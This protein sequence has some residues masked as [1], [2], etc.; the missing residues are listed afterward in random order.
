M[1]FGDIII[2]SSDEVRQAAEAVAVLRQTACEKAPPSFHRLNPSATL[3]IFP[4]TIHS[5]KCYRPTYVP[6][7]SHH[8]RLKDISLF[9]LTYET[10]FVSG[11]R[12]SKSTIMHSDV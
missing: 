6:L 4:F 12:S 11:S 7:T 5:E 10:A 2:R 1:L 8:A 9:L 3:L